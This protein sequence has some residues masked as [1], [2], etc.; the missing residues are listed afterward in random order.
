MLEETKVIDKSPTWV[1]TELPL[2]KTSNDVKCVFKLK[3]NPN[4][5][6]FPNEKYD[7][8]SEV[9]CRNRVWTI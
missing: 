4:V 9:L 2:N 6:P 8:L 5:K 3:L 7:Y 1:L